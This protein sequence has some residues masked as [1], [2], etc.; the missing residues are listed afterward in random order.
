[1]TTKSKLQLLHSFGKTGTI[2]YNGAINETGMY[3][4]NDAGRFLKIRVPEIKGN[5]SARIA[6]TMIPVI[7]PFLTLQGNYL[8]SPQGEIYLNGKGVFAESKVRASIAVQGE[9]Q[10]VIGEFEDARYEEYEQVEFYIENANQRDSMIDVI[11][12]NVSLTFDDY[13]VLSKIGKK[14]VNVDFYWKDRDT[15]IVDVRDD[16]VYIAEHFIPREEA[17]VQ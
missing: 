9:S 17:H 15:F 4:A 1:M 10:V 16:F 7:Y 12:R 13:Q 3:A 5:G 14:D 11:Q 2:S 6:I 8:I